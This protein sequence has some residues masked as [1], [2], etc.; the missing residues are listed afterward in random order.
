MKQ[1]KIV[2]VRFLLLFY[3]TSSYLSATHIHN[4]SVVSHDDCKV[5]IVVKNLNSGDAPTVTIHDLTCENCYDPIT[6]KLEK[7]KQSILK[8]FNANAPPSLS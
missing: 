1:F 7:V 4:R 5:C 6:F 8:G 3:L 2:F